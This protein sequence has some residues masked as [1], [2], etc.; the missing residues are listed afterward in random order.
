MIGL[1]KI[2][3]SLFFFSTSLHSMELIPLLEKNA[4]QNDEVVCENKRALVRHLSPKL[5]LL[6]QAISIP[7]D[8]W[9]EIYTKMVDIMFEGDKEF[10]ECFYN[11]PAA[12]ALQLYRAI[13]KAVGDKPIAPLYKMDQGRCDAILS[14]INPWYGDYVDPVMSI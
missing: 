10:E 12:E 14:K 4:S 2:T 7:K 3:L 8:I 9:G 5:F 1:H 6:R 11:K 13:K